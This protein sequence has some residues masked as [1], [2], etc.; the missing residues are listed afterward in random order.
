MS[1]LKLY[2]K[3]TFDDIKH[4]D[5]SGNEYWLAHELQLTLDYRKCK[6]CMQTK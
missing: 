6:S 2:N 1:E 4:I 5:E 3:K